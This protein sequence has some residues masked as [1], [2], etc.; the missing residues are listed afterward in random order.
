MDELRRQAE[1]RMHARQ[2]DPLKV[3]SDQAINLLYELEVHQ[4]ELEMQNEELHRSQLALEAARD[5]YAELFDLAPAGYLVLD[6]TGRIVRAN[7]TA[8]ELLNLRRG[9]LRG[10]EL[11]HCV[12]RE[13][14][15]TLYQ[16]LR[17]VFKQ[18]A[19]HSCELE[20][21]HRDGS[22]FFAKLD[23][24]AQPTAVGTEPQC[25]TL[26]SDISQFKRAEVES[27]RAREAAEQANQA[28][29][30]FLAAASHDLRQPLQALTTITDLLKMT[31]DDTE[32]LGLV[33]NMSK[34]LVN[35]NELFTA[36]LHINQ[37][38][39][40]SITPEPRAFP[41]GDLLCQAV[42][43]YRPLA[44]QKG[45]SLRVVHCSAVIRSDPVLLG[46]IV[47]N[48]VSNAI[49]YTNTGRVLLG[50]RR[51]GPIVRI[52]VWDTGIGIPEDQRERIFEDYYQL[53]NPARERRKGLGLGLSI[54]DRTARLLQH[55]IEMTPWK[56]GS[57]FA[58]EVPLA[59][60]QEANHRRLAGIASRS[61]TARTASVL[62]VD[63]NKV[64]RLSL[65][66]LLES[67]GFQVTA[68][69]SL[70]DAMALAGG[71]AEP[72]DF[73]VTD[74]RLPDDMTGL[75]LITSIN[76]ALGSAVPAVII[77]G[78]LEV[79]NLPEVAASG[80]EVLHKPVRDVTLIGKIREMLA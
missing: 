52:E 54:V 56:H 37:L 74:Y 15:D 64:V 63:D 41:A 40:G 72:F 35:M 2:P 28:K 48:L 6:A 50:C 38:E 42:S 19:R 70:P 55:E 20:M 30:H 47:D 14:R 10:F 65:T 45:L 5:R 58:V 60:M 25:L 49:R 11:T 44:E 24:V 46:E 67:Y 51:R 43:A 16:H 69:M 12:A 26:I 57:L 32:A 8:A 34:C 76:A 3:S 23:S 31:L 39:S 29:S 22:T 75:E 36:L 53:G 13:H 61:D 27:Q 33:G 1:S 73:I 78:D 80:I 79:R 4:I 7:L 9:Q 21:R 62:V 18:P 71:A 17:R 68:A 59:G 66:Y 77:T